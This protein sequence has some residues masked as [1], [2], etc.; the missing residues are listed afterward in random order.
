MNAQRYKIKEL[1]SMQTHTQIVS[2]T[3]PSLKGKCKKSV[4]DFSSGWHYRL[5]EILILCLPTQGNKQSAF[6]F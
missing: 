2:P 6:A 1:K 3:T 4:K 5:W